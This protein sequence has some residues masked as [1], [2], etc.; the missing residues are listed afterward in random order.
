MIS[1]YTYLP[2]DVK[3][4]PR[5]GH[6]FNKYPASGFVAPMDNPF[7]QLTVHSCLPE[8]IE[9]YSIQKLVAEAN[10][11]YD[12]KMRYIQSICKHS[13]T[14]LYGNRPDI[15]DVICDICKKILE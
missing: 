7:Q 3:I 12:E 15:N 6:D 8:N 1:E 5:C 11:S 2:I 4:C 13:K 14:S 10:N 9:A